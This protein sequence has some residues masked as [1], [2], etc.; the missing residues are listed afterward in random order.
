MLRVLRASALKLSLEHSLTGVPYYP[1]FPTL[2]SASASATDA[3]VDYARRGHDRG[4]GGRCRAP[5]SKP[6]STTEAC[7]DFFQSRLT[8]LKRLALLQKH[9]KNKTKKMSGS[10]RRR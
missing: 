3:C 4:R 6:R 10:G 5:R 1:R 7:V 8:E 9:K 2:P